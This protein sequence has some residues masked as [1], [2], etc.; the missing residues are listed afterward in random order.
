MGLFMLSWHSVHG[1]ED[2]WLLL[3]LRR[4]GGLA[5]IWLGEAFMLADTGPLW[6]MMV[7]VFIL[8]VILVIAIVV[9]TVLIETVSIIIIILPS[10]EFFED[11]IDASL[12]STGMD[13]LISRPFLHIQHILDIGDAY[14]PVMQN[15]SE[16]WC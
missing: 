1:G 7:V 11:L 13:D 3:W 8:M 2:R 16:F 15:S 6:M 10:V 12:R 5:F 4:L 9:I 14:T